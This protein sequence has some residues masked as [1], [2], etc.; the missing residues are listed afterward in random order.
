MSRGKYLS[1]EEARNSGKIKQFAKEHPAQGDKRAVLGTIKRM[2]REPQILS[3]K[4]PA[5]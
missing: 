3:K 2:V 1:L 5:P 4:K